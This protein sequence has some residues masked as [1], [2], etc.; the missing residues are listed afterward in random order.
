MIPTQATPPTIQLPVS[1]SD[2]LDPPPRSWKVGVHRGDGPAAGGQPGKP[3][4]YQQS[5]EGDDE[6]GNAEIGDD[7]PLEGADEGSQD[8]ADGERDDP[9][10]RVAEPIRG[11]SH[12]AWSIAMT[13]PT[14]P[15]I[16]PTE[17]S[18]F[19][20]TMTSTIPVA[21]IATE[22]V[23][24]ERFHRLRGVRNVPPDRK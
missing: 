23:C 24:T 17:R 9:D 19:R 16:E 6:G 8:H 13:M 1:P 14:M 11:G 3:T 10:P 2:P 7:R 22:E 18:M 20:E 5:A 4:P 21:M 15:T 12:S